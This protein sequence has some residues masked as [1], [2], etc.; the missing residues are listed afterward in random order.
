MGPGKGDAGAVPAMLGAVAG[1]AGTGI[2]GPA[3]RVI[4]VLGIPPGKL[5][6]PTGGSPGSGTSTAGALEGF[7]GIPMLFGVESVLGGVKLPLG[8][9]PRVALGGSKPGG[10]SET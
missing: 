2:A 10:F 6:P 9:G 5:V 4:P 7:P 1:G 8:V 3:S